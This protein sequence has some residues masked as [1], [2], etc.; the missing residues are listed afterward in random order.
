MRNY[1]P[2]RWA[3]LTIQEQNDFGNGC[4]PAFFPDWLTRLLFGWF[5]DASCR[6]YDFGYA[7]GGSE[8]DRGFYLAMRNDANRYAD[9]AEIK[10]ILAFALAVAF[11]RFVRLFGWLRFYYGPYRS[12]SELL[13]ID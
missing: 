11:Y 5:F 7:R 12:L 2:P 3:D 6:R 4:D 9:K 8:A 13:G 10:Y 1:K